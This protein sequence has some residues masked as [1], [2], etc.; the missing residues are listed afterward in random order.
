M[1]SSPPCDEAL[2]CALAVDRLSKFACATPQLRIS[3]TN[4]GMRNPWPR[5]SPFVRTSHAS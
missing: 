1:L 4:D 3:H 2:V 5:K